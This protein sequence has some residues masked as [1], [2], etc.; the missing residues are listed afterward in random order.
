MLC[1]AAFCLRLIY[2]PFAGGGRNHG[3]EKNFRSYFGCI[4]VI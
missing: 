4:G 1:D 3:K 2:R